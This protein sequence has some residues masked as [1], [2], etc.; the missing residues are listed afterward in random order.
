MFQ[1]RENMS[2]KWILLDLRNCWNFI[3][4]KKEHNMF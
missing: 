3:K 4:N 2:E 1:E